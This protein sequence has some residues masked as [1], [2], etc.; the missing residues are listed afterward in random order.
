[1]DIQGADY[2]SEKIRISVCDEFFVGID[3]IIQRN[4]YEST[5]NTKRNM[6]TVEEV[7]LPRAGT[8][9]GGC[10]M[11]KNNLSQPI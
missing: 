6:E 9:R 5:M 10:K 1:L 2:P 3:I 8:F 11:L 4:S 7:G